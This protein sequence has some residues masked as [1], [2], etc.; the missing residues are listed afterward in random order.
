MIKLAILSTAKHLKYSIGYTDFRR[1]ACK[2]PRI[3]Y[4]CLILTKFP[5]CCVFDDNVNFC[6]LLD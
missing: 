1:G 2:T 4:E 3:Y 6:K 5:H